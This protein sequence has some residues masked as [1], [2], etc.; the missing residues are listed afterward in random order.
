MIKKTVLFFMVILLFSCNSNDKDENDYQNDVSEVSVIIAEKESFRP[1]LTFTGTIKPFREANLGTAIPGRVEKL[2]F[3]EGDWVNKGA[4]LVQL[5]GEATAMARYE[6]ET[7]KKDYERVERLRERGSAT[8]QDYD[9]VKAKFKAAEAKYDFFKSNSEVRAPF[10]G[11]IVEYLVNEGE[12]FT[13]SPGLEPGYSHASGILR[14]MQLNPVKATINV[15]ENIIPQLDNIIEVS[16]STDVYTNEEF[17]GEITF[18]KPVLSPA[19][20]TAPVEVTINNPDNKLMP[21]M[22]ARVNLKMEEDSL[23]FVPRHAVLDKDERTGYV[24]MIK[25]SKAKKIQINILDEHNG[26]FAVTGIRHGDTIA[27]SRIN[28]LIENMDVKVA[29]E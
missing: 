28:A 7:L 23:V 16:I 9:H 20:R 2:Y 3:S 13:F 29:G 25:R 8:Q 17:E 18:I 1:V 22:F 26:R 4:L 14:L 24:W 12:T 6:Y 15:G 11:V 27:V 5:S 19:S 21:G 10:S